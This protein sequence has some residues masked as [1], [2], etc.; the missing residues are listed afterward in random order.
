MNLGFAFAWSASCHKHAAIIDG[1]KGR[2]SEQCGEL[3]MQPRNEGGTS[4]TG[5]SRRSRSSGTAMGT[6]NLGKRRNGKAEDKHSCVSSVSHFPFSVSGLFLQI[7][8]MNS[9]TATNCL[10]DPLQHYILQQDG[11]YQASHQPEHSR[12]EERIHNGNENRKEEV[13]GLVCERQQCGV[14]EGSLA[15]HRSPEL[16]TLSTMNVN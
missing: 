1:D 3:C 9:C 14:V 4:G 12:K 13:R 5:L 8:E 10:F 11:P 15:M 6:G 7:L 16:W 2:K